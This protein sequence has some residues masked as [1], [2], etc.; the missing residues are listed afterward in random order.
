MGI[1]PE[2]SWGIA[3]WRERRRWL[4]GAR[5]PLIPSPTGLFAFWCC[6]LGFRHSPRHNGKKSLFVVWVFILLNEFPLKSCDIFWDVPMKWI[7][8]LFQHLLPEMLVKLTYRYGRIKMYKVDSWRIFYY[9]D[10]YYYWL[11]WLLLLSLWLCV[12]FLNKWKNGDNFCVSVFLPIT[13]KILIATSI[14]KDSL[15]RIER[16]LEVLEPM[17]RFPSHHETRA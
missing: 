10:D 13:T 15:C 7:N 3:R 12:A 14:V 11:L 1:A 8:N 9:Y 17:K 2:H 5:A 16:L 6:G 4:W